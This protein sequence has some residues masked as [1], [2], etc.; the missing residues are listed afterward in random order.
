MAP[1]QIIQIYSDYERC[2][3]KESHKRTLLWLL[4]RSSRTIQIT[5][6]E[7]RRR[8]T[9]EQFYSIRTDYPDQYPYYE[10][11]DAK[12]SR[13]RTL[14]WLLNRSY[15]SIQITNGGTRRRAT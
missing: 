9:S 15:R 1:E 14:L 4:N 2:D 5:N 10:R 7:T 11:C 6:G 12:E 3:E 13:K 8:A